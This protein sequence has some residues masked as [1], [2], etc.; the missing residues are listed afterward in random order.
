MLEITWPE[1]IGWVVFGLTVYFSYGISHSIAA[2]EGKNN[3]FDRNNVSSG[4]VLNEKENKNEI[5]SECLPLSKRH[6]GFQPSE[7]KEADTEHEF[8]DNLDFHENGSKN[9]IKN[10]NPQPNNLLVSVTQDGFVDGP[11]QFSLE[12]HI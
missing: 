4:R 10:Y 8:R 11:S 3:L 6:N 1:S 7:Y 2:N 9:I 5:N 12:P